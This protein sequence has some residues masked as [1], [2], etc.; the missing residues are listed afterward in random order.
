M[1]HRVFLLTGLL[2]VLIAGLG[3]QMTSARLL[4]VRITEADGSPLADTTG[5][6]FK[7]TLHCVSRDALY[8][9]FGFFRGRGDLYAKLQ[10]GN[11]GVGWEAGDTVSF[12][13]FRNNPYSSTRPLEIE[14]P[15]GGAII[16]WGRPPVEGKLCVGYPIRMYPYVLNVQ[17]PAAGTPILKDGITTGLASGD[18]IFPETTKDLSG[19][20]SL[21]PPPSGW[22][23]EPAKHLVTPRDF[24]FSESAYTDAEGVYRPGWARTLEFRLVPS[25]PEG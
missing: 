25:D 6:A 19:V 15:E 12:L 5:L 9:D 17:T 3:A 20:F 14:I 16:W 21:A 2:A 8:T 13:A 22:R 24:E 11:F 18:P 23:W 4:F 1:K 10:L 7:A